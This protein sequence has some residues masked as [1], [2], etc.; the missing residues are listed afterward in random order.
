MRLVF[1][2]N[3][4]PPTLGGIQTFLPLLI[5]ELEALGASVTTIVEQSVPPTPVGTETLHRPSLR[6][7]LKLIRACDVYVQHCPLG[8]YQALLSVAGR[9]GCAVHHC[10]P[11][12]KASLVA[13]TALGC[14]QVAV[15]EFIARKLPTHS[16]VIHNLYN[17]LVFNENNCDQKSEILFCGRLCWTKGLGTLMAAIKLLADR[18]EH[19][20]LTVAGDGPARGELAAL[21]RAWGLADR[22]AL[23]GRLDAEELKQV[24]A[25][26]KVVAIPSEWGEPFGLVAFEA[27]ASGCRIVSTTDGALPEILGGFATFVPPNN[28][29]CLADA[30]ADLCYQA[31]TPL[32]RSESDARATYLSAFSPTVVAHR[33]LALFGQQGRRAPATTISTK[34][35]TPI[36]ECTI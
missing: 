27:L 34:P 2:T 19:I 32:S 5:K 33:Y 4:F 31:R 10:H 36:K 12:W 9:K 20:R 26:H 25:T 13:A 17:S 21:S 28:E 23:L 6:T 7:I 15:S 11:R 3:S 35:Q 14:R 8:F 18:G 29:T 30:L 24:Y 1:H 22:I 16:T